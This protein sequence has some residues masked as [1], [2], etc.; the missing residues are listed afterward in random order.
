MSGLAP[1]AVVLALKC[2]VY[3]VLVLMIVYTLRH[4]LFTMNRLFGRQRH[5]YLD[6]DTADWPFVTVVVPAPQ[7]KRRHCPCARRP[8]GRRLPH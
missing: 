6:I 4:V 8:G 3:F 1:H 5:P 2:A 7:R